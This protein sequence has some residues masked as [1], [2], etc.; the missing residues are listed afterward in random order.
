MRA[1]WTLAAGGAA[2]A[3]AAVAAATAQVV[4]ADQLRRLEAAKAQSAAAAARSA[5]LE[6]AAAREQD[7][8]AQARAQEAA[9]A[10]RIQQAEADIAAGQARGAIT[11]RL[12]ADQRARLAA[13]QGP[14]A[15][16]IAAL[17]SLAR[18]PAMISLVQPGSVDDLVHVRAVLASAMPVVR[19][20]TAALRTDLDRT[21]ALQANA[22]LAAAALAE[23]RTRL[24]T[25]RLALTRLEAEHRLKSRALGRDAL[26]ESDRAIALG[27]RARD[28]VDL[29]SRQGDETATRAG[30]AAL[31][32]PLPRPPRPGEVVASLGPPVWPAGSAPYR[33]P[34][35]GR[36]VT[37][38]GEL[39]DAGVRA[40]GLTIATAPAALVVAPAAGKVAYAGRFRSYGTI[41]IL[42]HGGGWTTLVSGLDAAS[43]APGARVAQGAVIGTAAKGDDPRVTVELRRRDRAI[44][45]VPLIG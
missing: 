2:V 40:R 1:R 21:R 31:P 43:V 41:V 28:I 23:S 20:R 35:A 38:L 14:I 10:A 4:P 30:L 33:L 16:L 5:A 39:S 26:F 11:A 42:D 36:V 34:V 24:E 44:D 45:M 7:Q 9:M 18:R 25:Q 17:Q 22:A 27:E 29:M 37:G 32:G 8:A 6:A 13:R 3:V 15:R 19:A 12:L